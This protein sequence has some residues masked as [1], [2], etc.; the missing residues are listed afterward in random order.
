MS[1][2]DLPLA[3]SL[4]NEDAYLSRFNVYPAGF[5]IGPHVPGAN[6]A[7]QCIR[8]GL[9]LE[10]ALLTYPIE[11]VR[12]VLEIAQRLQSRGFKEDM[13]FTCKCK[14]PFPYGYNSSTRTMVSVNVE[15][16]ISE[17][18]DTDFVR[19][20][21]DRRLVN[22]QAFWGRFFDKE[23]LEDFPELEELSH[24]ELHKKYRVPYRR[25]FFDDARFAANPHLE[26]PK[27]YEELERLFPDPYVDQ[28]PVS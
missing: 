12:H 22:V 26:I 6:R 7:G 2:R 14:G 25:G 19:A 13:V 20:V 28:Q 11:L 8:G 27:T 18:F 15:E 4:V 1:Y 16:P 21:N 10:K 23:R 24:D 3:E 5:M 9:V 17:D